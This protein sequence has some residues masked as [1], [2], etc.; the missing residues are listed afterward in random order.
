MEGQNYAQGKKN[1][2][3]KYISP[4]VM[5]YKKPPALVNHPSF[6]SPNFK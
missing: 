2:T 5:K 6:P 4:R 1:N 3:E